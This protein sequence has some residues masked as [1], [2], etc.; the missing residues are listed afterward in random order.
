MIPH[1]QIDAMS[2]VTCCFDVSEKSTLS[3]LHEI[4]TSQE[5]VENAQATF[6]QPFPRYSLLRHVFREQDVAGLRALLER[7]TQNLLSFQ[8][9]TRVARIEILN[10]HELTFEPRL[11]QATAFLFFYPSQQIAGRRQPRPDLQ[12]PLRPFQSRFAS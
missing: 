7:T 12:P 3:F 6:E 4:K 5:M 11:V 2:S 1:R 8:I 10:Q 9:Q